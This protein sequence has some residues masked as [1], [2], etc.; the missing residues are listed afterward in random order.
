MS[1]WTCNRKK[2]SRRTAVTIDGYEDVPTDEG[3][4]LKAA[5]KQPISVGICA[6]SAMQFYSGGVIDSGFFRLKRD[7]GETG[8]CGIATAASYPI[9]STP[10]HPV[11]QVSLHAQPPRAVAQ[12]QQR[13]Q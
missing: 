7:V 9:K 11:P 12:Q 3:S 2:E 1:F 13:Q 10:N 4:L 8:L 5:S 6:S